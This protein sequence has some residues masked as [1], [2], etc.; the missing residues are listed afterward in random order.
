[1]SEPLDETIQQKRARPGRTIDFYPFPFENLYQVKVLQEF[2]RT[3]ISVWYP[4][5]LGSWNHRQQESVG[6]DPQNPLRCTSSM[7]KITKINEDNQASLST[8]SSGHVILLRLDTIRAWR[9]FKLPMVNCDKHGRNEVFQAFLFDEQ[10]I[11]RF[12]IHDS[13]SKSPK[14][15]DFIFRE[16]TTTFQF[17]T[18]SI[19][20]SED[21]YGHAMIRVFERAVLQRFK[22]AKV[23]C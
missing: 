21:S 16:V 13:N 11:S 3:T 22:T 4:P 19:R 7:D 18:F 14:Y 1:M 10:F 9:W 15:W 23:G 6:D 20:S 8:G 2:G 5:K 17:S 12:T